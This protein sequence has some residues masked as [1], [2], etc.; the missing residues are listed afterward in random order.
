M[1]AYRL[2]IGLSGVNV[3]SNEEL[4]AINLAITSTLEA[5]ERDGFSSK[6]VDALLHMM[7]LSLSHTSANFGL[8][9]AQ[10]IIQA[11]I[12]INSSPIELMKIHD[13]MDQLRSSLR[14][15]DGA[16]FRSLIRQYLLDN[17]RVINF[18]MEA[19]PN[20]LKLESEKETQLLKTLESSLD[21]NQVLIEAKELKEDQNKIQGTFLLSPLNCRHFFPPLPFSFRYPKGVSIENAL[22]KGTKISRICEF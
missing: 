1:T 2:G 22:G 6:R 21:K 17:R 10:R 4:E 8:G 3:K 11:W 5:V 14:I 15:S 7:E 13:R 19:D 20:Y 12:T 16:Y 9:L 18:S